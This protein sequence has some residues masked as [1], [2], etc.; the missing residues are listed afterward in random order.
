M[1]KKPCSGPA[2]I[3]LNLEGWKKKTPVRVGGTVENPFAGAGL[4]LRGTLHCH[5]NRPELP[6]WR[7]DCIPHYKAMGYDLMAGMDHDE[8]VPLESSSDLLV[9]PGVEI[10]GP[11]H[12]LAYA[13]DQLPEYETEG[14]SFERTVAMVAKVKAMG[15]I[16]V[17]AHPFKSGYTWT[18]LHALCDAGL[19]GIEVINSNVRGKPADAG[20]CDQLW[21]NLMRE[22]RSLMA[23]GND[24]AH[25]P[26]EPTEALGPNGVSRAAWTGVL[27][28]DFT[29][30]SVLSAIR[31]G[32]TYASEGPELHDLRIRED[33]MVEI[34]TSPCVACHC[35]SVGDHWG[36]ASLY[37][38]TGQTES[39]RFELDLKEK[40]YRIRDALVVVLEDRWGR[41][42]WTSP[43]PFHIEITPV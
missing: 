30:E 12:F 15:G 28:E 1:R 3:D 38:S 23:L 14:G 11:G 26:H 8:I 4:W 41:R 24:D 20:R 37:P 36:G 39:E 32:K 42:A 40:G 43:I 18:Q 21:H 16:A 2:R 27:A 34:A 35:R 17:L 7:K 19:D 6:A 25:G 33:G 13:I 5:V 31:A 10:S 9:V 22:G 29:L